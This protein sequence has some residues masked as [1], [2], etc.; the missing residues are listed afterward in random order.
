MKKRIASL[1]MGFLT[2]AAL[3]VGVG[4]HASA[5]A[6]GLRIYGGLGRVEGGDFNSGQKGWADFYS[7]VFGLLSYSPEGGIK[8]ARMGPN[9]GAELLYRF[10]PRLSIG[11]GVGFIRAS[12][13]SGVSFTPAASGLSALTYEAE[14]AISAAP[15]TVSLHYALPIGGR[16]SFDVHGGLGPY[17]A[18]GAASQKLT[19]ASGYWT[20]DEYRVHGG[21]LGFHGGLGM[22]CAL[23]RRL[24]LF[25]EARGRW[26]SFAN[27]KG[28]VTMSDSTGWSD[29]VSGFLWSENV[30][31]SP[32]GSWRIFEIADTEPAGFGISDVRRT[33]IDF[34]GLSL[35]LGIVVRL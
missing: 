8:P 17:L 25:A 34:S 12:E 3:P 31:L 10:A 1:V 19:D 27:F 24:A 22:E 18:W 23:S 7:L 4:A 5:G 15:V 13:T 14:T 30:D 32:L 9:A 21:G 29:A 2:A 6:F 11:L 20:L 16:I 33:R 35:A 26:A 28:E